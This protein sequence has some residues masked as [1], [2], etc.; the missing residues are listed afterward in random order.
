MS[1]P[2][3]GNA[4][5][6]PSVRLVRAVPRRDD[7]Y[8]VEKR[9]L[10]FHLILRLAGYARR[11]G[12]LV[13]AL[14]GLVFLRSAQLPLLT[15]AANR[16]IGGPISDGDFDA[17][18]WG[19]TF[20]LAL[21]LFTDFSFHFRY[22]LAL[23]F[24]EAV[25]H[26]LR[27]EIVAHLHRLPMSFYTKT[28]L[29]RI[30]SRVTNDVDMVRTGVQNVLFV[31]LVQ[32]GQMLVSAGL[33][34]YYD[35]YL[36]CAVAALAPPVWYLNRV[37]RRHMSVAVREVQESYSRVTS[38]IAESVSGIRVTQGFARQEVN[39]AAFARLLD[40]HARYNMNVER[41]RSFLWPVLDLNNNIFLAVLLL[42]GGWRA[43]QG[44]IGLYDLIQFFF[45]A[46]MFFGPINVIGNQYANALTAMAGAER[47]FRFLDTEPEWRDAADATELPPVRGRLEF[48]GLSFAYESGHPVLHDV[49]FVVEPGETV[50]L[51]GHTGCGKSTIVALIAKFYLPT[52]GEYLIDGREIRT[53]T[54]DSLHRQLGIV[55]QVN[56]LFSGT[57][58][59]NIRL[60]RPSASDADVAD[61][62]RRLGTLDLL[63]ALPE[64]LRTEVGERGCRLSLG[65]RQIVCFT[66][67]MLADPRIL[68]LDEATSS[69]DSITELRVQ[70]A[71]ETLLEGRTN[72]IVAH[73]LS[74]IVGADQVLV[75]DHGRVV[76]RGRHEELLAARGAYAELYRTFSEQREEP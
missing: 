53:V 32:G 54:G 29:G 10:D 63:E 14:L 73:R 13:A 52:V 42:G 30:L 38:T 6:A 47:I 8:E 21:A 34:L 12:H 19:A 23:T 3:T 61:A 11:Y 55:L 45:F 59:E 58:L 20:F 71:L 26:D 18:V 37:Y 28:K 43:L 2:A 9:P 17:V 7:D 22:R 48:R 24:G 65:Q 1:S 25:V 49:S 51:V 76:E 27:N 44:A 70:R 75:I 31:S 33:M 66:R 64:G 41:A 35:R 60:A 16:V 4:P 36:F 62:A 67:T 68:L 40:D 69:V 15:W 72:V 39:A 74:T 46:G 57:V 5:R 56:F 50:A